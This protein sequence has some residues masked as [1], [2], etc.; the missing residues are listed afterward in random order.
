M[1]GW[2]AL[3]Y[4]ARGFSERID[5]ILLEAGANVNAKNDFGVMP[6]HSA[7]SSDEGVII[8]PLLIGAGADIDAQ[9][10]YGLTPLYIASK[11]DITKNIEILL[12]AG[13]DPNIATNKGETA[14]HT[15]ARKRNR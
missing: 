1:D 7:A 13:A 6:I 3:H 11:Y 8:L 2:T 10:N 15:A 5:S 12:A 9:P 14:L 4:A